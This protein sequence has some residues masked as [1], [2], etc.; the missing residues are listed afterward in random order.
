MASNSTLSS[1]PT[2]VSFFLAY[3]TAYEESIDRDSSVTTSKSRSSDDDDY[4]TSD[5]S[6]RPITLK[7]FT[8][9]LPPILRQQKENERKCKSSS[10]HQ[11]ECQT[12][13]A[14]RGT[15]DDPVNTLFRRL[16]LT[17]GEWKK[18]AMFE[19]KKNYTRNLIATDDETFTLLLLCWNPGKESP[20]HDHPCDG[21]WLRVCQGK[22]QETRYEI[23]T[24]TD[25]MDV[26]SDEVFEDDAPAFINDS[27]GYHKVGNPSTS[28]PAITLHLYC[29]PFNQCKI[30]LDPSHASSPSKACMCNYSEYGVKHSCEMFEVNII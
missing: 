21:C 4:D 22:I 29:P 17:L 5:S 15:K 10:S 26:T 12:Q 13:N 7:E 25:R 14:L 28:T 19:S 3:D 23:N 9:A 1:S 16:D 18:Y 8:K 11:Q 20:I 30:W 27:M 24:E 2:S 6:G